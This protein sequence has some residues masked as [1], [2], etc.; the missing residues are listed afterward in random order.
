MITVFS[1]GVCQAR[2]CNASEAA[3]S[4][5]EGKKWFPI[6]SAVHC[7]VFNLEQH[8]RITQYELWIIRSY[9]ISIYVK[10]GTNRGQTLANTTS[11]V[12]C[13]VI[14]RSKCVGKSSFWH[15][16]W[17]TKQVRHKRQFKGFIL[18]KCQCPWQT[19]HFNSNMNAFNKRQIMLLFFPMNWSSGDTLSYELYQWTYW[20]DWLTKRQKGKH[21]YVSGQTMSSKDGA[22][23]HTIHY[24]KVNFSSVYITLCNLIQNCIE[25]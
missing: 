11:C 5:D 7:V 10:Q 17:G 12:F 1:L 22:R 25:N 6:Q 4:A 19:H 9:N 21:L 24:T 16:L 2:L 20:D 13:F 15:M 14:L 18:P 8:L 23:E 3:N